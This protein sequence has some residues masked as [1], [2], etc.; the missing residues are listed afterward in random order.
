MSEFQIHADP[1]VAVLIVTLVFPLFSS[2][3][4]LEREGERLK[5]LV[6]IATLKVGRNACPQLIDSL[7]GVSRSKLAYSSNSSSW[8]DK[9]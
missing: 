2:L 5:T 3:G 7:L 8:E 9:P 4:N 1:I 6:P